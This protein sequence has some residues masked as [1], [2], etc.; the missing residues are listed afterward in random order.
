MALD[1]PV[2]HP[3]DVLAEQHTTELLEPR[4]RIIERPDD[5][6]E[7]QLVT[8]GDAGKEHPSSVHLFGWRY[9]TRS[10]S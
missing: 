4:R 10:A 5:E 8:N 7:H 2:P 1:E 9:R 6:L 3:T